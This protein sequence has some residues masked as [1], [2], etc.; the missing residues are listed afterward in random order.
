MEDVRVD[1]G[2]V[3]KVHVHVH[4]PRSGPLSHVEIFHQSI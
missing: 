4:V 3:H 2:V 1:Q